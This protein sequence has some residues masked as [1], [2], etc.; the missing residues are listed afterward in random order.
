MNGD[1]KELQ[2]ALAGFARDHGSIAANALILECATPAD[3]TK[4]AAPLKELTTV[5]GRDPRMG[6]GIT[7]GI[8]MA[9]AQ[10]FAQVVDR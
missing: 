8:I 5:S 2:R 7:T 10:L 4:I 9:V 1:T 3:L 6:D